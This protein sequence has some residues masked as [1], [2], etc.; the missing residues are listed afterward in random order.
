M[1]SCAA[2]D[3]ETRAPGGGL[4]LVA[5]GFIQLYEALQCLQQAALGLHRDLGPPLVQALVT[6][7]QQRFGV[8]IPPLPQQAAAQER[9]GVEGR[10]PVGLLLL[11]EFGHHRVRPEPQ[12]RGTRVAAEEAADRPAAEQAAAA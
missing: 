6:S 7:E 8:G 3:I 5:C 4:L 2:G 12:L 10:P 11:A 9:L 1:V